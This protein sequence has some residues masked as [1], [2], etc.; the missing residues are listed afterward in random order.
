ML[1][2]ILWASWCIKAITIWLDMSF[3]MSHDCHCNAVCSF[4]AYLY[5]FIDFRF[6]VWNFR[7]FRLLHLIIVFAGM[8]NIYFVC[9]F[10]WKGVFWIQ[11]IQIFIAY[12][13]VGC[14]NKRMFVCGT[15]DRF[16]A[17]IAHSNCIEVDTFEWHV[18]CVYNKRVAF[19]RR[20]Q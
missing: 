15:K 5:Y 1:T 9:L 6:N 14:V 4:V 20:K 12:M 8:W 2:L 10:E 3:G 7:A 13:W 11:Y 19:N 17:F 16:I 18:L